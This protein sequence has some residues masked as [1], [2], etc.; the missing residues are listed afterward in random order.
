[1]YDFSDRRMYLFSYKIKEMILKNIFSGHVSFSISVGKT[2]TS[3]PIL[4]IFQYLFQI[5]QN[6]L[7]LVPEVFLSEAK[8]FHSVLKGFVADSQIFSGFFNGAGA[9]F[10]GLYNHGIFQ[11]GQFGG[12]FRIHL[13]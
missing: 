11:P 2:P 9:L 4:G 6:K 10:Q 8:L 1:M 12:N 7:P 5:I 3:F 13:P